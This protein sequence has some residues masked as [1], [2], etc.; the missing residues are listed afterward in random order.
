M[1]PPCRA[2]SRTCC[3]D[4]W[5]G[6]NRRCRRW[7]GSLRWRDAGCRSRCC[8][9]WPPRIPA[10]LIRPAFDAALREAVTHHVLAAEDSQW[11]AFR[12]ALLA[13]A[14]YADLLP[15]ELASLHRAYLRQLTADPSL[16]SQAQIAHHALRSH[17]LPAALAA[18]HAAAREA[19]EVLAPVEELRHLETVLQL[20]DAVPDAAGLAGQDRIEVAMAAA[21]AASRAGQPARAAALARSALAKADPVRA[22]RITPAAVTYLIDEDHAPEALVLANRALG[23]AGRRRS[24]AGP[25]AAAGRAR[26]VGP[27]HRPRRR[28]PAHRGTRDHRVP[29]AR[30]GRCGGGRTDHAGGA[31]RRR[32]GPGGCTAPRRPGD[33]AEHRAT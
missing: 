24:V 11:I 33:R 12:H 5:R 20:W 10:S 25:R 28:G 9:R 3:T 26:Q 32:R 22:A 6:S 4:G 16:G 13:E 27:E 21:A 23:G 31:L 18:S 19:A 15:G 14:V 7:P 8:G 30:G 17:E 2:R 29:A 1:P